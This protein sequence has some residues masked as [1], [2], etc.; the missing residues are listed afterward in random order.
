MTPEYRF[1]DWLFAAGSEMTVDNDVYPRFLIATE[2]E[3]KPLTAEN[4]ASALDNYLRANSFFGRL[5]QIFAD[6]KRMLQLVF[7][8]K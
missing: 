1:M 3:I 5:R 8:K 4:D 2:N 7:T 6:F